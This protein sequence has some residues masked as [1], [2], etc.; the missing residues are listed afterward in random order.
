MTVPVQKDFPT[1][2][3]G[4][5]VIILALQKT[6][7]R[8]GLLPEPIGDTVMREQAAQLVAENAGTTW[9]QH[10]HR[11]TG[12]DVWLKCVK[13]LLQIFFCRTEQPKIIK[14]PATAKV[15]LCLR[16]MDGKAGAL[17]YLP[18]GSSDIGSKII[19]KCVG[20]ENDFTPQA[21]TGRSLSDP[22]HKGFLSKFRDLT[23]LGNLQHRLRNSIDHT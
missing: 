15:F 18:S 10:N 20:K 19:V 8:K 12:I 11:Q 22:T 3:P 7:K 1:R 17:E 23:F 16:D 4:R 21:A 5:L 14:W 9:F 6:T 13:N 2:K